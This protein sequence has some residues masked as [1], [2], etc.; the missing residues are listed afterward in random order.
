MKWIDFLYS[1]ERDERKEG[2]VNLL[3]SDLNTL[4]EDDLVKIRKQLGLII[5][6]D[7]TDI[8]FFAKK[9]DKIIM[10]HAYKSGISLVSENPVE[11]VYKRNSEELVKLLSSSE[12]IIRI[13]ALYALAKN[14]CDAKHIQSLEKFAE[15][16]SEDESVLAIEA[17]EAIKNFMN[18]KKEREKKRQE[19]RKAVLQ[20]LRSTKESGKK[21]INLNRDRERSSENRRE[22]KIWD[23]DK[24]EKIPFSRK[25]LII[26]ILLFAVYHIYFSYIFNPAAHV[27]AD[28][29]IIYYS[30]S[31]FTP[32]IVYSVDN[33]L[34]IRKLD[35]TLSGWSAYE[36]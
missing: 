3:K 11:E 28:S 27:P 29:E 34:K 26:I 36:E 4:S 33:N 15:N 1:K 22:R 17:I 7:D 25:A 19:K 10:E 9:L 32:A 35:L 20:S 31:R 21:E 5:E 8:R 23:N 16:S 6:Q 24:K 2:I 12:K 18:E 13:N 30:Y 14:G